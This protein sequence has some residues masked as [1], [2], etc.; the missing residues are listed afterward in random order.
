METKRF[1]LLANQSNI[2]W[3]GRKVTGAHNGTIDFKEGSLV[4]DEGQ[5]TGGQFVVDISSLKILDIADPETNANMAGHLASDDFFASDRFPEAFFEIKSVVRAGDNS[6]NIYGDLTIKGITHAANFSAIYYQQD[7][8][9]SAS[10]KIVVDR[11]RYNMKFRSGNFFRN[12][13][14]TLIYNEFD[15]NVTILAKAA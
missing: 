11:T 12:L 10:G 15:L 9:F 14:D 3:V 13:G 6:Y 2:D 8:T 1:K 4:F 5:L 7:G